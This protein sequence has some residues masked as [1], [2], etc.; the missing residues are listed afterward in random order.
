VRKL[1]VKRKSGIDLSYVLFDDNNRI[2]LLADNLKNFEAGFTFKTHL[3][4]L[5]VCQLAIARTLSAQLS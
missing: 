5:L 2:V 4:T 3:M 1:H